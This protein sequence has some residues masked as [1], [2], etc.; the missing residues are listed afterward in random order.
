M[1]WYITAVNKGYDAH[2][3]KTSLKCDIDSQENQTCNQFWTIVTISSTLTKP[4]S[5]FGRIS[6]LRK[7]VIEDM[8]CQ[9]P[10]S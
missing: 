9:L 7:V 1:K 4:T 8:A 6:S 3:K 10:S 5:N 2:E